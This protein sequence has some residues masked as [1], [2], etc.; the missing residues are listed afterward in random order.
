MFIGHSDCRRP[1][2]NPGSQA[3]DMNRLP[4]STLGR[5]TLALI[6]YDWLMLV[7]AGVSRA[8]R[9]KSSRRLAC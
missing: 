1:P 2:D 9:R 8:R 4:R 7:A 5:T 3:V 6:V